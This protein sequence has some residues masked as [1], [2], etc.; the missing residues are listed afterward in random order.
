[1]K[2]QDIRK[3]AY[4]SVCLLITM[5]LIAVPVQAQSGIGSN[6]HVNISNNGKR[7]YMTKNKGYSL[8]VEMKGDI[9]LNDS[10]TDIVS[11]SRGGYLEIEEEQRGSRHNLRIEGLS[12]GRL[13]YAYKLNGRKVDFADIDRDWYEDILIT[14]IR[15]TGAGAE[16]RTAR[17]LA[18]DGVDG[19]FREINMIESSSSRTRYMTHLFE[20]AK[21]TDSQL[22]RAAKL[23]GDIPSSGDRSRFLKASAVQF[24]ASDDATPYYF[25]AVE[26]IPSSGDKTRVLNNLVEEDLLSDRDSY[27]EAIKVAKSIPSSGDRSRFLIKAADL[28]IAE[29]SDLYFDA[30]GS[31]PSSG[32]KTRV[33]MKL[34]D[35]QALSDR[36]A[37]IDA[38]EIARGI[39]SSGDRARFL[40][41]ASKTYRSEA[42]DPYFKAVSSLPSS[43]DHARVLINLANNVSLDRASMVS[44]LNSAKGISS[45]GDK[46]RVLTSVADDV[47]DD[48]ELVEAY[49]ETVETISSSGDYKR[50]LSA[51]M[52]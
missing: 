2:H 41:A 15:E 36:E 26:S 7:T 51:L 49:I 27:L 37:Y 21:L 50:A 10:D 25:D 23:A 16:A 3:A 4:F 5:L 31:I 24:L 1:M 29:A 9:V 32:D 14:M 47:A 6:S 46:A 12:G 48:D 11:I 8:E 19:V 28:Y 30:V 34:V 40:I 18:S 13:S 22:Q 33:L 43:G 20:Q 17:I 42:R 44:F 52:N 45:S 35:E 38:M 39:P